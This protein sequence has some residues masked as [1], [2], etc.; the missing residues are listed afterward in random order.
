MQYWTRRA[1]LEVSKYLTSKITPQSH[2]NRNSMVVTQKQTRRLV[3][4]NREPQYE[5]TQL[6]PPNFWQRCQKYIMEKRQPLQQYCWENWISACREL[7]LDPCLLPSTSIN[8]KWIKDTNIRSESLALV[9][10]KSGNSPEAIGIA[11][12]SSVERK[13][14]SKWEKGLTNGTTWS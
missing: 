10:E 1:A 4:Q 12:T 5:S 2:S 9:Q 14:L 13:Q 11:K 6:C 8:S 3:E 7:K